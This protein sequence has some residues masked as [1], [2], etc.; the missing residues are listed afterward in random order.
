MFT[1]VV[2]KD[3]QRIL[4]EEIKGNICRIG[5]SPF[6]DIV[7]DFPFISYE[8]LVIAEV[9][10]QFFVI[11]KSLNGVLIGSKRPG[12]N[13]PVLIRPDERLKT[14]GISIYPVRE[15]GADE[16]KTRILFDNMIGGLEVSEIILV[17]ACGN[18]IRILSDDEFRTEGFLGRYRFEE[19]YKDDLL[20]VIQ[21]EMKDKRIFAVILSKSRYYN[22]PV[23]EKKRISRRP[24]LLFYT[25]LS[26][27][28]LIFIL[29]SGLF[30]W[31]SLG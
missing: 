2:E 7:L 9:L 10:G 26:A 12:R 8:H 3:G 18:V 4:K 13:N 22:Y 17:G 11:D 14:D 31:L 19:K 16:S 28:A 25:V 21:I 20:R 27:L 5:R 1:V 23:S 6:S 24:G 30:V 15:S 29:L